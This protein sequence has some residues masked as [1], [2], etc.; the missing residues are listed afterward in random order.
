LWL[1]PTVSCSPLSCTQNFAMFSS[2]LLSSLKGVV[3][4]SE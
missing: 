2:L 1:D 4:S 3:S